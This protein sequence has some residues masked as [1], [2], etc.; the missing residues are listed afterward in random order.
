MPTG[1]L[2]PETTVKGA[3]YH[4]ISVILKSQWQMRVHLC[5]IRKYMYSRRLPKSNGALRPHN[6]HESLVYSY[7]RADIFRVKQACFEC[8]T[9]NRYLFCRDNLKE[10]HC[11]QKHQRLA[12]LFSNSCFSLVRSSMYPFLLHCLSSSWKSSSTALL[13]SS[14]TRHVFSTSFICSSSSF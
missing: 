8:K 4:A 3:R 7:L 14:K 6:W 9:H 10:R 13:S 5:G 1:R 11:E 2:S 12:S